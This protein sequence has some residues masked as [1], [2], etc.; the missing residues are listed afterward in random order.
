MSKRRISI[1]IQL[2]CVY[3]LFFLSSSPAH[4]QISA[5]GEPQGTHEC[6]T[7]Q[8]SPGNFIVIKAAD[9]LTQAV[10]EA[11]SECESTF[12][13]IVSTQTSEETSN[14][15]ACNDDRMCTFE[16][17][18]NFDVELC[19]IKSHTPDY[20]LTHLIP[21]GDGTMTSCSF[22]GEALIQD[23]YDNYIIHPGYVGKCEIV[24]NFGIED[25]FWRAK[26]TA[27]YHKSE[28]CTVTD[29]KGKK[30]K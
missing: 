21:N 17:N 11:L 2:L 8:D 5:N 28:S 12:D 9:T 13:N 7:M 15:F 27:K 18:I 25:D 23:F 1:A 10:E 22:P 16:Y 19:E 26:A 24:D 4:A 20:P 3:T 6:P 29:N 30:N 14:S